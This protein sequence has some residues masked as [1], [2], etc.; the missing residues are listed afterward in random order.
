MLKRKVSYDTARKSKRI[1]MKCKRALE[2]VVETRKR[3]EHA[4]VYVD[5]QRSLESPTET[6]HRQEQNRALMAK[7]EITGECK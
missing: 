3:L 1:A 6:I 7:K 4:R 2:T 5:S